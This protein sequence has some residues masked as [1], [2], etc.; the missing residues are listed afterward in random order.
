MRVYVI[1]DH[2]MCVCVCLNVQ[3]CKN[4]LNCISVNSV[5]DLER[6]HN[7]KG[8]NISFMY[9][10]Y[11]LYLMLFTCTTPTVSG[12]LLYHS[13]II[14]CAPVSL[15]QYQVYSCV[16]L[17]QYQVYP[18]VPLPLYQVCSCT[19]PALSGVLLYHSRCIRCTPV[20]H[21]RCIRCTPMYH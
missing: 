21:S 19:T 15:L 10:F 16:P 5:C 3:Y 13:R 9:S 7:L 17:P 18:C 4:Y 11:A 12:V 20:Y 8:F 6:T 14:R 2:H 1:Y